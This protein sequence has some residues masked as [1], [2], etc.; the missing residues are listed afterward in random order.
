M[1]ID[2]IRMFCL[3]LPGTTEGMK[4]GD[5]LTFMVCEKMFAIFSLDATPINGSFKVSE[6][7]FIK[8]SEYPNMKP[9]P[10]FA[11]NMWISID[12]ISLLNPDE[13]QRILKNAYSIIRAKL[14]KKV[15]QSLEPLE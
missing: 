13:W 9:A 4:W 11:K 10:Y 6:E 12:D 7:E 1:E 2:E 3:S 14:P 5:N 15:Q 8:M